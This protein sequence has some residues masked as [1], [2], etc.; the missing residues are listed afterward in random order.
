[1]LAAVADGPVDA[2]VS[3]APERLHRSPRGLQGFIELVERTG[4]VVETVKAGA[5]DAA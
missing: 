1:M 5:W 4:C 3:W 2:L